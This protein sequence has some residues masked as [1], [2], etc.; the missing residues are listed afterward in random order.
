MLR[1]A[2]QRPQ[3]LVIEDTGRLLAEHVDVAVR[4]RQRVFGLMGRRELPPSHGLLVERC[5]AIH[6]AFVRFR[7]DVVFCT[8]RL[9]VLHI[10]DSVPPFRI[11]GPVWR[12]KTVIELP[13][14]TCREVGLRVGHR[15]KLRSVRET[16]A[17]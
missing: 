7:I 5:A 6:T 16:P 1:D 2:S 11:R 10:A 9:R 4:L 17:P 15:L 13:A 14:G 12:A 8:Q 3:R